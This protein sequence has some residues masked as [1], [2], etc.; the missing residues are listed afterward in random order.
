MTAPT[1][2]FYAPMKPPDHPTPSGDREMARALMAAL[3]S[4][5]HEVRLASRLRS[6]QKAPDDDAFAIIA[7]DG[8]RDADRI[9]AEATAPGARPP[10][11]FAT[12]HLYHKAADPIG[13]HVADALSIPYCVIEASRA[14]KRAHGPWAYGLAAA[15]RA[16]ARADAVIALQRADLPG[17]A[18]VVGPDRLHVIPPFRDLSPYLA[19]PRREAPRRAAPCRLLAV[20]MMREGAKERS[21]RLLADALSRLDPDSWTLDIAG[22]G[23]A[24]AEIAPLFPTDRT[25][26]LGTVAQDRLP[27]VYASA[28]LFVWPAIEEAFGIVF[29]EA[30]ATG[31]AVVG[32]DRGGVPDVVANGTTGL[33]VDEGDAAGFAE[34]V[35]ALIADPERRHRMGLAARA[36]ALSRHH[37]PAG[38]KALA[39]ILAPLMASDAT[40]DRRAPADG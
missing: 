36:H 17:L 25:R 28:D 14:A 15:D 23:P 4:G 10:A 3:A 40:Q 37:L 33:L 39:R 6:W 26:F 30:Q 18:R 1:I 9:I 31:L 16:L 27:E 11:L 2:L 8:R 5:G 20:G 13:P 22:D 35:A 19:Q 29:L 32:A 12:Y 24:R 21:Y 7:A 38:A 34:A